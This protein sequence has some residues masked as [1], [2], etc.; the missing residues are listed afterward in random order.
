MLK[1]FVR[2]TGHLESM[3][4]KKHCHQNSLS[5][6]P[7]SVWDKMTVDTKDT[8]LCEGIYLYAKK[9]HYLPT[10]H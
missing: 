2:D 9:Y 8:D 4:K 10:T 6:N 7:Q 3:K 5:L 1:H